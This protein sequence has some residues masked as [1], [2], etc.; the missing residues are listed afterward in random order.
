[1]DIPN[2]FIT[3]ETKFYVIALDDLIKQIGEDS[4]KRILSF[5]ECPQNK[6]VED[7]LRYKAIEFSKQRLAKTYL[8]YWA[9]IDYREK[10]L[11]GYFTVSL[12]QI[13]I[14]KKDL[15]NT[16]RKAYKKYAINND[17]ESTYDLPAVLIGQLGKN[18]NNSNDSLISGQDLLTLAIQ[19]VKEIYTLVG[20]RY[21]YLECEDNQ[22]LLSFYESNGFV[23]F[24]SRNLDRDETNIKGSKLIQ[25]I[26]KIL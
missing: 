5:F 22:R 9:T 13:S 23:I 15:S 18:F 14:D 24:G 21:V 17:S 11:V 6:D 3:S 2:I 20:G 16:K 25:L 7:F 10:E 19:K 1:M 26:K 12:K 4:T 8:V